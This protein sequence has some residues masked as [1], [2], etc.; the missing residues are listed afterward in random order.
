ME[1]NKRGKR[2]RKFADH[3][4]MAVVEPLVAE[5]LRQIADT[6]LAPQLVSA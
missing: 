4:C 3:I 2:P 5:A 1:K 6:A